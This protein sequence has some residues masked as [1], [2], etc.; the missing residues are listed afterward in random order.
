MS[1]G[2]KKKSH[3]P[4]GGG[5][6]EGH[7]GAPEWLISF[8]DNTALIMG[9][10]VILLAL[11]MAPK[12]G[13]SG[14]EGKGTSDYEMDWA[15]AVRSAFHNPVNIN[16]TNP[17]DFQ[18]VQYLKRKSW[19]EEIKKKV[20]AEIGKSTEEGIEGQY[21]SVTN[22]RE[23]LAFT[24]GGQVGFE[25]GKAELLDQAKRQI[26]LFLPG[27]EGL[28]HKI[29]IRGHAAQVPEEVYRPF[30]SLDD[31]SYA[32]AKAVK[33]YMVGKGIR[34]ERITIEACGANEPIRAQAYDEDSRAI[35]R[36]VSIIVMEN[37]VEEYQG[38]PAENKGDIIDG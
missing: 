4:G 38:Q 33:D 21:P 28:N 3:G 11:N 1:E 7:E 5:H 12:G 23:G 26:D 25:S 14:A 13:G 20:N 30:Q 27:L 36:R 34:Q 19:Q 8:A 24:I 35:N 16:S 17:R 10:F 18:L 22:I 29:C 37:L 31:L 6:E 32:R 2:H 9:F 15:I